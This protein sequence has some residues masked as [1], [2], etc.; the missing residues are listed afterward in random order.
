MKI[1]MIFTSKFHRTGITMVVMNYYR[2]RIKKKNIYIDFLL[3]N[4][5][6]PDFKDEII[7]NQSNIFPKMLP[8]ESLR[9]A[10]RG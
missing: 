1:L 10:V 7:K 9:S 4:N 3:P 5:P 8:T 6:E 2:E